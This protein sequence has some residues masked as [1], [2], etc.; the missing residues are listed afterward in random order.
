MFWGRPGRKTGINHNMFFS[1]GKI[2]AVS[3]GRQAAGP[4]KDPT[5]REVESQE[6]NWKLST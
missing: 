5:P 6:G 1:C 3:G 4:E 2:V